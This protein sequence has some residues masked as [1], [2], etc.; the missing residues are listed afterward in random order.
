MTPA[1]YVVIQRSASGATGLCR[2]ES[3]C[4][5]TCC[6]VTPAISSTSHAQ[7]CASI[8]QHQLNLQSHLAGSQLQPLRTATAH[9]PRTTRHAPAAVPPLPPCPIAVHSVEEQR[10]AAPA[11]RPAGSDRCCPPP[12]S[13]RQGAAAAGRRQHCSRRAPCLNWLAAVSCRSWRCWQMRQAHSWALPWQPTPLN[14]RCDH[15][16]G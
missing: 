14:R 11:S 8:H 5:Y 7:A 13:C 9:N 2:K 1:S 6:T 12:P 4:M 16:Q 3:G 10:H 15:E